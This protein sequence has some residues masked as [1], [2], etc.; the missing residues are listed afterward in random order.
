MHVFR[1]LL[2]PAEE[3]WQTP[4]ADIKSHLSPMKMLFLTRALFIIKY[5]VTHNIQLHVKVGRTQWEVAPVSECGVSK[6][7]MEDQFNFGCVSWRHF[8]KRTRARAHT[9]MIPPYLSF[10]PAGS[11]IPIRPA[12]IKVKSQRFYW[13]GG[14]KYLPQLSSPFSPTQASHA[15]N[16][17]TT[18]IY[19]TKIKRNRMLGI[20]TWWQFSNHKAHL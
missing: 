9:T 13:G 18:H 2:F 17:S 10:Q 6:R 16:S 8:W 20:V 14:K 7:F 12:M 19:Q 15:G 4:R 5:L 11:F 1:R 3:L